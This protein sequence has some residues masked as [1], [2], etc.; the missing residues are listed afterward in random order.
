ML[1]KGL[2]AI[3][4]ALS[5]SQAL[6]QDPTKVV[7]VEPVAEDYLTGP[8]VLKA[9]VEP[10][11]T[12]VTRADFFVDGVAVCRLTMPPFECPYDAGPRVLPRQVRVAM[13]MA[14]GRRIVANVRT[15]GLDLES[16]VSVNSVLVPVVVRDWRGKFVPGLTKESFEL[17]ED[18]T[19]QGVTFFQA[20]N[21]P[22]EL[23]IAVDISDS[24]MQ[25]MPGVK[26]G[27]VS[28]VNRLKPIDRVTLLAFNERVFVV[29]KSESD[30]GRLRDAIG[31]LTP[32]GGTAIYDALVRSADSL[33]TQISRRAIVAFTDGKDQDSLATMSAVE[34]R[35]R[36]TDVSLHLIVYGRLA[37]A[38]LASQQP[39]MKLAE[40]TGGRVYRADKVG[41]L[42]EIFKDVIDDLSQHYLLGYSPSNTA[43]DGGTRNI[44]ITVP[45]KGAYELKFRNKYV[46]PGK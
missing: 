35:F 9:A 5:V 16:A 30:Q 29:T 34:E 27:I 32:Q 36:S 11:E 6:P 12:A 46:A 1:L 10:V 44:T 23:S 18:G 45:G 39:L 41:D 21:I 26:E 22:L 17:K 14:D 13:T 3:G 20:E 19:T 43:R 38:D 25:I 15:T 7:I 2:V 8:V 28:F 40:L 42:P 24:M 37:P 33:G 4:L 31:K